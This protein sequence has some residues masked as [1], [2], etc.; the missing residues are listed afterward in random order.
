LEQI[1]ASPEALSSEALFIHADVTGAYMN[2]HIV[3][4]GGVSLSKFPS[5][6]YVYE[7][8]SKKKRIN[9]T[10]CCFTCWLC[11]L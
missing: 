6:R 2:N 3:S 10:L 8:V 11:L 7:C 4:Q 1:L 5:H 9:I